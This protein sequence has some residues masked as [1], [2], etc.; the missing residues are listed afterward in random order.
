[1]KLRKFHCVVFLNDVFT[2]IA[3]FKL[4]CV[5]NGLS[6]IAIYEAF[7]EVMKKVT[8]KN[9][10]LKQNSTLRAANFTNV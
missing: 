10:L 3:K 5:S 4:H 9:T 7:Y 6:V 2:A 8:N 1:M